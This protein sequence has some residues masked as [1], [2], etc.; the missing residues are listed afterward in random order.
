MCAFV[1]RLDP[2]SIAENLTQ[3][4]VNFVLKCVSEEVSSR[5]TGV[6]AGRLYG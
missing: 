4:E 5:E 3:V 1:Y 6:R 2:I